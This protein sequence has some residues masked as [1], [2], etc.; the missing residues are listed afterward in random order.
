MR[1]LIEAFSK[2]KAKFDSISLKLLIVGG[3]SELQELKLLAESLGIG[4]DCKFTGRVDF[5]RIPDYHNMMDVEVFPSIFES[6]SFG[7]SVLEAS[8]CEKPVV[9]SNIGGL[10]EVVENGITGI[11]IPPKDPD[12]IREATE[13]LL[14][15]RE[16]RL[17]MGRAGRAHVIKKFQFADNL[18]L[19]LNIYLKIINSKL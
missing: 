5:D 17:R 19:M 18:E 13:K 6:E 2:L 3:G 15:N 8:A 12:S 4:N 14:L 16:L 1:Y 7:V 10:P 9:V 11:I